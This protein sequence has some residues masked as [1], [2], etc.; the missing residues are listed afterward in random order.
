VVVSIRRITGDN[1]D[2]GGVVD[3]VSG[4]LT[5][6]KG[7]WF[8][9]YR[10]VNRWE[11]IWNTNQ[12][13]RLFSPGVSDW[14]CLLGVELRWDDEAPGAPPAAGARPPVRLLSA[15]EPDDLEHYVRVGPWRLRRFEQYLAL[16]LRAEKDETL[17]EAAARWKTQIAEHVNGQW[18]TIN[19]YLNWRWLRYKKGEPDL[20]QPKQIIL[21]AR[22]WG[23]PPPDEGFGKLTGPTVVPVARWQPGEQ[24]A[25]W[26]AAIESYDPET[27]RFV[28]WQRKK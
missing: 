19:A 26:R 28:P 7:H 2:V 22:T 25:G 24:E 3:H 14:C 11:E 15:D 1:E 12:N 23:I 9:V 8:D 17:E 6:S 16:D 20:P 4:G 21:I 27:R 18:D 5:R 10:F 13:W